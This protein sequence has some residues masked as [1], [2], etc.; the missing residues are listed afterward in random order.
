MSVA[1]LRRLGSDRRMSVVSSIYRTFGP[2]NAGLERS[3]YTVADTLV[4]V[5]VG[6]VQE[7]ATMFAQRLAEAIPRLPEQ[8][9]VLLQMLYATPGEK[10]G[11]SLK[12]IALVL[13]VTESWISLLHT[14]AMIVLQRTLAGQAI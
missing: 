5:D 13:Q 2:S 8:E 4:S 9:R 12:D 3:E 7:E 10:V 14:R 11:M 1:D 6:G